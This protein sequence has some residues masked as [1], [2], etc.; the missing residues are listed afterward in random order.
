MKKIIIILA[1]VAGIVGLSFEATIMKSHSKVAHKNETFQEI[2]DLKKFYS[3]ILVPDLYQGIHPLDT[4]QSED[5]RQKYQS[6]ADLIVKN[7][8]VNS[9]KVYLSLCDIAAE[10]IDDDEIIKDIYSFIQEIF[11]MQTGVIDEYTSILV[12]VDLLKYTDE[13][14]KHLHKLGDI[15]EADALEKY[16]KIIKY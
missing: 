14:L 16:R 7:F 1:I 15:L 5:F 11:T 3:D 8:V 12:K 4:T 13:E 2:A 9:E 6:I 10:N